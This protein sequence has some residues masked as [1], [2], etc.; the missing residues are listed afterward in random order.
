MGVYFFPVLPIQTSTV[1]ERLSTICQGTSTQRISLDWTD[2][3]S[4]IQSGRV[5]DVGIDKKFPHLLCFK[6]SR[7][8]RG[9]IVTWNS[10]VWDS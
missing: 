1:L 5:V 6:A 9:D 8:S 3:F 7:C 2:V 4:T 10:R